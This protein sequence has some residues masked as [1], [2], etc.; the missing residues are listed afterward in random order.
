MIVASNVDH[1]KLVRHCEVV[2]VVE[3]KHQVEE[4]R[5]IEIQCQ[6]LADTVMPVR[7]GAPLFEGTVD[8]H[9]LV[10]SETLD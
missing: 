10:I 4:V 2:E 1:V 3:L 6:G 5:D 9:F 8:R 7:Y